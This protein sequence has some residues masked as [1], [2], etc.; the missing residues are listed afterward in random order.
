MATEPQEGTLSVENL[1]LLSSKS[2]YILENG[3]QK[4]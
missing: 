4:T 2:S 3:K 1:G